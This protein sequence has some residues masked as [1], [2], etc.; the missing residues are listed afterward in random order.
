MNCLYPEAVA[1]AVA[2]AEAVAIVAVAVVAVAADCSQRRVR[3]L[4]S[5][6][7][8]PFFTRMFASSKST[9]I[10]TMAFLRLMLLPK[11]ASLSLRC[12]EASNETNCSYNLQSISRSLEY[13]V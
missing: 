12:A 13:L 11:T 9:L 8:Q 7:F 3:C 1:S 5:P 4:D 10:R 6:R 2:A